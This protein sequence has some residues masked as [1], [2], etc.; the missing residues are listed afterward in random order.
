MVETHEFSHGEKVAFGTLTSPFPTD[1]P[2]ETI[3]EV[4]DFCES[5]G[6]PTTRGRIGLG[7]ASDDLLMKIAEAA[8]AEGETIHNEAVPVTPRMVVSAMKAADMEG[9]RMEGAI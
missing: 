3:T 5:V 4:Y 6:P 2:E 8:C 9:R 7:E 1:K